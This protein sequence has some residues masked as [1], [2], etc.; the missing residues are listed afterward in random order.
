MKKQHKTTFAADLVAPCGMNCA[1][2]AAFLAKKRAVKKSGIKMAYC[3]GCRPRGKMCAWLKKR[4]ALI[5]K[6]KIRFCSECP[7]FP[8]SPLK[9]LDRRY[10]TLFRMS[11]LDNLEYIGTSGIGSFLKKD[12]MRWSCDECGGVISCHNGICFNCG[13]EKLKKKRV[14][15]RWDEK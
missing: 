3:A 12:R 11:M 10:R 1:I 4:C 6:D 5:R 15:H 8:C 9:H 2:C 14:K 7:D 13:L